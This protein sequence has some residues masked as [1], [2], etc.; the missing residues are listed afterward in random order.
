MAVDEVTEIWNGRTAE[1]D[2]GNVRSY[3]RV[4][5]VHTNNMQDG[6]L[7]LSAILLGLPTLFTPYVDSYGQTD[8][9]ALAQRYRPRNT[10]DPF[11]WEVQVDYSSALVHYHSPVHRGLSGRTG[12]AEQANKG[13]EDQNPLNRPP[14]IRVSLAKYQ[15]EIY[16]SAD[17]PP[18]LI[19]NSAGDPF[20]PPVLAD[21][22]RFVVTYDRNEATLNAVA[23]ALYQDATNADTFW[24]Q[25]P[26][27]WKI[28]VTA[29]SAFENGLY[30]WRKTYTLELRTDVGRIGGQP[31]F[32]GWM[33]QI[34][35][36]GLRELK[37]GKRVVCLDANA[38]AVTSPVN[39]DGAGHQQD[40]G[41]D[42]V[43]GLPITV[44]PPLVFAP[45]QLIQPA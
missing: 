45:L 40:P 17:T 6:P 22:T 30:Y 1:H 10:D 35:D 13:Q 8:P 11:T 27:S 14:V 12:R 4:F 19:Q 21:K 44:Y 33:R 18:L 3:L 25:S 36:R 32:L 29:E 24:Q 37:G 42:P 20:D 23:M 41:S 7:Q 43:L 31:V 26:A 9:G 5:R 15:Q 34:V 16:T 28:N 38:H 2:M 39:L